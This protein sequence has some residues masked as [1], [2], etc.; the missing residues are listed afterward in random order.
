MWWWRSIK[1][2]VYG[3][4]SRIEYSILQFLYPHLNFFFKKKK[5]VWRRNLFLNNGIWR[6]KLFKN[7][8]LLQIPF[9]TRNIFRCIIFTQYY[10]LNNNQDQSRPLRKSLNWYPGIIIPLR[11]TYCDFDL[12]QKWSQWV[13]HSRRSGLSE[14]GVVFAG[15]IEIMSMLI[16]VN[17]S[18]WRV[19]LIV[20]LASKCLM[21]TRSRTRSRCFL[22]LPFENGPPR[23]LQVMHRFK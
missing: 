12:L 9:V 11:L 19:I 14:T 21:S 15:D 5:G 20:T 4:L 2:S 3:S 1:F 7:N 16:E 22:N 8:C 6:R 13:S 23:T 18:T 17:I 10:L